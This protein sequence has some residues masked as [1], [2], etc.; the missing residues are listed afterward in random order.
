MHSSKQMASELAENQAEK[1]A[2]R[3]ASE[4]T[5]KN[6]EAQLHELQEHIEAL[7]AKV[8]IL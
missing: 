3:E 4:E 8:L 7:Q 6:F 5:S 1:V 2:L